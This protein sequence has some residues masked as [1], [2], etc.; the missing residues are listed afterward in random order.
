MIMVGWLSMQVVQSRGNALPRSLLDL[1]NRW[2]AGCYLGIVREGY[3]FSP[4]A[5]F[6]NVAF[7]PLH[8]S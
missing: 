4:T 8:P 1:L 2:D 5:D 3:R 7:F 6:N